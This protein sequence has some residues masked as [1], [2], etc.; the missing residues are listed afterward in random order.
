MIYLNFIFSVTMSVFKQI[1]LADLV[2][3]LKFLNFE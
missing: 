3:L 2:I 1:I